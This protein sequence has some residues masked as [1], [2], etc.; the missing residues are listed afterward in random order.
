MNKLGLV[1]SGGGGKGAYE[2]GVWKALKEFEID[3]CVSAVAGTSIGG[4]NGAMFIGGDLDLAID[5]WG[6]ISHSKVLK[7]NWK[8]VAEKAISTIA[9]AA[10]PGFQGKALIHFAT[11]M[12]GSTWFTQKGVEELIKQSH[13]CE[14]V[15]LSNIPLYVCAL[16]GDNGKLVFPRLNGKSPD[17]IILWLKATS[18]IPFVFGSVEINGKRYHDGGVLPGVFSNNTPFEPLIEH[19]NCTHIIN[20]YLDRRPVIYT[21]QKKYPNVKFW[22]IIPTNE[23]DGLI[24]PLNFDSSNAKKL[25]KLGYSDTLRV[26]RQFKDFKDT[27]DKY[28]DKTN[29]VVNEHYIFQDKIFTN[30]EIR[31]IQGSEDKTDE[32]L[33]KELLLYFESSQNRGDTDLLSFSK[34]SDME[35]TIEKVMHEIASEIQKEEIELL[36]NALDNIVEEVQ[37]NSSELLDEAFSSISVLA[38]TEGRINSQTDQKFFSRILGYI[39]GENQ[40]LQTDINWDLNRAIYANQQLISKLNGKHLLTMDAI[41]S[42]GNKTNYLMN[43][44]NMLYNASKL[45][46]IKNKRF[47]LLMQQAISYVIKEF[48]QKI[49]KANENI[50][51][52]HY[53]NKLEDWYHI[54]QARQLNLSPIDRLIQSTVSF[55]EITKG[56]WDDAVLCRYK[57]ALMDLHKDDVSFSPLDLCTESNSQSFFHQLNTNSILP[58]APGKE[59]NYPILKGMQI[60]HDSPAISKDDFIKEIE[61]LHLDASVKIPALD[62]GLELLNSLKNN[63]RRFDKDGDI[64]SLKKS[65]CDTLDSIIHA[66]ESIDDGIS[67]IQDAKLLKQDVLNYKVVVPVVGKFSSGKSTLLNCYLGDKYLETDIAPTTA[68][69]TELS[70]SENEYITLNYLNGNSEDKKLSEISNIEVTDELFYMQLFLNNPKLES[71]HNIVIVDMPGFDASNIQHEKAIAC[72][73]DRG[74]FFI[75]LFDE[76]SHAD[77]S[78]LNKLGEISCSYN[79]EF[80]CLVSKANRITDGKLRRIKNQIKDS[81]LNLVDIEIEVGDISVENSIKDFESL[82]DNAARN[83]TSLMRKRLFDRGEKLISDSEALIRNRISHEESDQD[84]IEVKINAIQSDYNDKKSK[85][86]NHISEMTFNLCSKGKEMLVSHATNLLNGNIETLVSAVKKNTLESELN[87]LL[88]PILQAEVSNLINEE[89]SRFEDKIEEF[90]DCDNATVGFGCRIP[91][92][93]TV[94]FSKTG[95]VIAGSL[96]GIIGA[97]FGPLGMIAGGIIGAF[98][99]GRKKQEIQDEEIRSCLINQVIPRITAEVISKIEQQLSDALQ[100]IKVSILQVLGDEKDQYQK[101]LSDLKTRKHRSIHQYQEK[102]KQY[103]KLL[104]AIK[105]TPV[106]LMLNE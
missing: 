22:N 95:A 46:E 51:Y 93:A 49:L 41:V 12:S 25:I 26:L 20:V 72:Y 76:I 42:L 44:V 15:A 33:G 8:K 2:V 87:A 80:G 85:I 75:C 105:N 47:L 19:E 39:T 30:Q 90:N 102:M 62:I 88:R 56:I 50:E 99:G 10:I 43:H 6:S 68:V 13:A 100:K 27:E 37:R 73:L 92:S 3:R 101:R 11:I 1:F 79:K 40:R 24:A 16:D 83:E 91:T 17:E 55:Y 59:A 104:E 4:L 45:Q 34:P 82:L 97:I 67:I 21:E 53:K 96:G 52:L 78:V 23:F 74:D 28:I 63:D 31:M 35:M 66:M 98:L 84:E 54:N 57:T 5:L 69:A 71:R 61:L 86:E 32:E 9:S 70:Y 36:N 18:A 65:Y 38:S 58:V 14:D 60:V 94:E 103:N 106:S 81:I 64:E 7:I 48:D 77:A 89:L 29:G